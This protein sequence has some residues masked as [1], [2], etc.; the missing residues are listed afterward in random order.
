MEQVDQKSGK[1]KDSEVELLVKLV[2]K[3]QDIVENK[4]TD[5]I[6]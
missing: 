5:A 6:T 4:K 3:H 2:N 1:F